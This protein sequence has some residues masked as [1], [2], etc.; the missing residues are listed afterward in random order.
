MISA[1]AGLLI[2]YL[3]ERFAK[4]GAWVILIMAALAL[5]AGAKAAYDSSLI[6]G[7]IDRAQAEFWEDKD[8]AQGK[9]ENE[10]D[11]RERDH[12]D[13]I[14]KTEDLIDE[15]LENGCAVGEYIASNGTNCVRG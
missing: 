15:A 13:R 2:P 12:E 9:A 10:S 1:L 6:Q 8:E 3:G 11:E 5:L 14:R 4:L 7:L